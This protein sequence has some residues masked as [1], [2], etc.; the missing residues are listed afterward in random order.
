M[1]ACT[2][3]DTL[4]TH[5]HEYMLFQK[6]LLKAII[7]PQKTTNGGVSLKHIWGRY[8][9]ISD[10]SHKCP[11]SYTTRK[12]QKHG[13][14]L[15]EPRSAS[16]GQAHGEKEGP[17]TVGRLERRPHWELRTG[18]PLPYQ[19]H[20]HPSILNFR[21]KAPWLNHLVGMKVTLLG[22]AA[23]G[24]NGVHGLQ[25]HRKVGAQGHCVSRYLV[26]VGVSF[27]VWKPQPVSSSHSQ[28]LL[29][30]PHLFS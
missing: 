30:L 26:R 28:A 15:F 6:N 12:T 14:A 3:T 19:E 17:G 22:I 2:H 24:G 23:P 10:P 5:R 16:W 25:Q 20:V 27:S 8:W 21:H 1:R 13:P 4:H 29:C 9:A 11:S 7:F 18:C